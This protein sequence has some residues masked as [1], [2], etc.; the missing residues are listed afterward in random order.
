M[1]F[2]NW[3]VKLSMQNKR[4]NG[5]QY[6]PYKVHIFDYTTPLYAKKSLTLSKLKEK[7]IEKSGIDSEGTCE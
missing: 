4:A 3:E 7:R 6:N 2:E 5:Y 1:K